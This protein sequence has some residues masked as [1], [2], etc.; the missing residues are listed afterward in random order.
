MKKT[1]VCVALFSVLGLGSILLSAQATTNEYPLTAEELEPS[2][3]DDDGL[4]LNYELELE[5]TDQPFIT[6]ESFPAEEGEG[7]VLEERSEETP[8]EDGDFSSAR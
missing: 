1:M 4:P 8:G 7:D 5:E 3:A 6:D 2:A